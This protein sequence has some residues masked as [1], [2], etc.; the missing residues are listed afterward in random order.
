MPRYTF[1]VSDVGK[2]PVGIASTLTNALKELAGKK[3]TIELKEAK[4][5]RSL[6]SNSYYWGVIIPAVRAFR[7][8]QGDACSPDDIH[9]DLL[10]CFSP[11]VER[12]SLSG[13]IKLLPLRSS[14]MDK[15]QFHK[16]MLTIESS[17]SE[18]GVVLPDKY[19]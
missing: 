17:L 2:L 8:E 15:E 10:A 18:F 3:C 14:A 4:D 16:Y 13:D 11:L 12:K 19:R 7:L 5:K 6:D 1:M 9:E